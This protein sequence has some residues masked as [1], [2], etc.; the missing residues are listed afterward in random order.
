ME[1]IKPDVHAPMGTSVALIDSGSGSKTNGPDSEDIRLCEGV[2]MTV[3][4]V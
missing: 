2:V 1:A 3:G 4:A